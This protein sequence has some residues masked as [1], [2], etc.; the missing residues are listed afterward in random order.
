MTKTNFE[1]V[2]DF[3][4]CFDH[5]VNT[6]SLELE[7]F[8]KQPKLVKLRYDLI[9]E[10]VDELNDAVKNNDVI[11]I[12]DAL[13]DILYV[14]YGFGV[15]FGIDLDRVF[16]NYLNDK[17]NLMKEANKNLDL[18]LQRTNTNFT[19]LKLLIKTMTGI[20]NIYN[21][22]DLGEHLQKD[23]NIFNITLKEINNYTNFLN[24]GIENKNFKLIEEALSNLLYE[25]YKFGYFSGIDLD[26]SFDIV[27]KSNMSKVCKSEE[28]AKKTLEWYTKNND[29]YKTPSYKSSEYGFIIY[30]KDTGKILKSIYY[31]KTDF[32]EMLNK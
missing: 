1:K 19:N 13:S 26:H 29:V 32:S 30:N 23:N 14:V 18:D 25:V 9:Q 31:N 2:I 10:E 17:L 6:T 22:N 24:K 20:N 4:T 12:I 11:E 16:Y 28:D 8:D 5:P 3:N 15:V 21:I 7:I 27:H